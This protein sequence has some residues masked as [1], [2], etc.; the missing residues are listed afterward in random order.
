M[1][2]CVTSIAH[3]VIG[4]RKKSPFFIFPLGKSAFN[5]FMFYLKYEHFLKPL[6]IFEKRLKPCIINI[7]ESKPLNVN[8]S[9]KTKSY[10]I[11]INCD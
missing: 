3:C 11:T 5:P 10:N 4:L 6:K 8:T 9:G 1:L 7:Y 2:S